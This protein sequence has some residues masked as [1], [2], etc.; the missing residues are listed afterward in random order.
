MS[1]SETDNNAWS[2]GAQKDGFRWRLRNTII[3]L[4]I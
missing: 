3:I 1:G 2:K 4:L